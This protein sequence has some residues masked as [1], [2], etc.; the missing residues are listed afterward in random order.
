MKDVSLEE[1]SRIGKETE[2]VDRDFKLSQ[3]CFGE[4]SLHVNDAQRYARRLL[5]NAR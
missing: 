2:S 3:D 5:E 1:I 4:N